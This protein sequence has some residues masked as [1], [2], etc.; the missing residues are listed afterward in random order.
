M[1]L[2]TRWT[3]FG[4]WQ[5]RLLASPTVHARTNT[6]FKVMKAIG[7]PH[8]DGP[9]NYLWNE[10]CG[11][12]A[13]FTDAQIFSYLKRSTRRCVDEP[14]CNSQFLAV[15][16]QMKYLFFFFP[17]IREQILDKAH[18]LHNAWELTISAVLYEFQS[19]GGGLDPLL[20][21]Y[22]PHYSLQSRCNLAVSLH[23]FPFSVVQHSHRDTC[24]QQQHRCW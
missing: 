2:W 6:I 9:P 14:E 3:W 8:H 11:S 18:T 21:T 23:L 24:C 13:I 7:I 5:V 15:V 20:Q 4:D 12:V 19:F 17:I 22:A 10:L 1:L 16:T